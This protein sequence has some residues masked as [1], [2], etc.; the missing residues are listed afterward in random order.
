[1]KKKKKVESPFAK[2]LA[3]ILQERNLSQKAVAEIAN[4]SPSVVS[5]W[6]KG[7]QPHDLN[8]L[9]TICQAIKCDFQW[10]VTGVHSKPNLK[11]I[12]LAEIFDIEDEPS[13]SGLFQIEAKRLTRKK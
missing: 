9:L 4:I 7:N 1:M 11:D 13:A 5:D 10:L 3:K 6:L 2:N 8:A 12:S